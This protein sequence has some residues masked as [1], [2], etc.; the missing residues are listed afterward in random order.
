M[1]NRP[2]E[3]IIFDH[4][5]TLI[6]TES[7]DFE[8]C[9][10]LCEEIGFTLTLELWA[11]TIVG[12]MDGYNDLFA[13]VIRGSD[14]GLTSE[15][16]WQRL[17]ELW[18]ITFEN[19]EL[20]P[21]ASTLIAQLHGMGYPLAIATASNQEWVGK[22]MNKFDLLPYFHVV[23]TGDDVTHNKPAPDVYHF[24]ARQLG[25]QPE[26]CLVFEDSVTGMQAAKAAGMTVVAVPNHVT[27]TL[28]FSQADGV[29]DGLEN[30]TVEWI[31]AFGQR[32]KE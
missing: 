22:W 26:R 25:V 31:E 16:L 12:R 5:G 29:V 11:E 17:K 9:K 10:L 13:E 20:M 18:K 4:D 30:V 27:K 7:P 21:G 2:F 15:H 3:A 8:G 28:N 14:N 24:A 32:V 19:V 1:K 23:A 6:D